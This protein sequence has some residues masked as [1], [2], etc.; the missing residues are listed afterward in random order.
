[1]AKTTGVIVLNFAPCQTEPQ[2]RI[3]NTLYALFNFPMSRTGN[4]TS[5][6][7]LLMVRKAELAI[8]KGRADSCLRQSLCS[9]SSC[10]LIKAPTTCQNMMLERL[11]LG[12]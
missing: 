2:V 10:V 5:T 6:E 8:K 9:S 11:L 12:N 7:V 1:M 3:Q 4:F